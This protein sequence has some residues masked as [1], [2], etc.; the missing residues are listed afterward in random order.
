MSA[1]APA[2][3]DASARALRD[4]LEAAVLA[5][6][7][8]NDEAGDGAA[9]S[10]RMV[11]SS[12]LAAL[13]CERL[14]REAVQHARQAEHSWATVG[15]LLGISRQAAQ[16][17]FS[18]P[19]PDQDPSGALRT[20]Y[21]TVGNEMALLKAEGLAGYHLVDF[22]LYYLQLQ[23]SERIWEHRREIA[24]RIGDKRQVLEEQGWTYVGAWLPFHYFKRAV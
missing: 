5:H 6:A 1:T 14:Q 13:L 2:P 22:G 4:A 18:T 20:L 24:L 16:Q 9:A 8:I 7:G 12:A 23:A 15:N 21:S 3:M 11:E 19:E 10:L 17:R